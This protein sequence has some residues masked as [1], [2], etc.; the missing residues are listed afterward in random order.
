M[1]ANEFKKGDLIVFPNL[2]HERLFTVVRVADDEIVIHE[3][4]DEVGAMAFT[5]FYPYSDIR[6]ATP[7]EIK[8]GKRLC[9]HSMT[10]ITVFGDLKRIYECGK[11]GHKEYEEWVSHD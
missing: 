10:E 3:V 5:E 2:P 1:K 8:A 7:E 11:C 9:T 6:H 4:W